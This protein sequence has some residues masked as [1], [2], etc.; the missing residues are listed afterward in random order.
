MTVNEARTRMMQAAPAPQAARCALGAATGRYLFSDLQAPYDDPLFDRTAVDG[1]ALRYEDREQPL[2]IVGSIAAGEV[3]PG[4]VQAGTCVR[5]FT[6]A[7]VPDGADSVVMQEHCTV[8]DGLMRL[9][10][11]RSA[12]GSNIRRQG[13]Q[14][15]AGGPLLPRGTRITASVVGLLASVGVQDVEVGAVPG[16]A[17][18]RTGSEFV[19]NGPVLPGLIF[20]SNDDQ[21]AAALQ[22]EGLPPPVLFRAKDREEELRQAL[23]NALEAAEVVITTGGV[24]VGEHDLVRR[25]LEQ[26]GARVLFHGVAQKPGKPML[27][28]ELQGRYVFGLPG[29]PRAVYILFHL[30]VLPFLRRMQGAA[31]PWPRTFR[32]PLAHAVQVKG[33]RAEFRAAAVQEGRIVLLADEGSH[34]L[35]SVTGADGLAYLPED[36]RTWEAGDPVDIHLLAP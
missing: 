2:R 4:P 24:S 26:L 13:E 19:D 14:V 17:I 7:M 15:R 23:E 33:E 9:Q 36:R 31:R 18:V 11:G 30:Y 1:Y 34:M 5:I 27:M 28:A 25:V 10:P 20:S 22:E 3:W 32:L 8:Q 16:T 29:N 35:R 21:L 6:G 12:P